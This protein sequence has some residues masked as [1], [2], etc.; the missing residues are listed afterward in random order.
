[1]GCYVPCAQEECEGDAEVEHDGDGEDALLE[2]CG[3]RVDVRY[4]DSVSTECGEEVG[5][6][7]GSGREGLGNGG[8]GG[9][10]A[11]D[12]DAL[13]YFGRHG[14]VLC[15]RTVYVVVLWV[16]PRANTRGILT[17]Y[18]TIYGV[19]LAG[20][21]S[22][23]WVRSYVTD[24]R[25]NLGGGLCGGVQVRRRGSSGATWGSSKSHCLN[26]SSELTSNARDACPHSKSS[27]FEA[28]DSVS[29]SC[30]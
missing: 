18:L 2:P 21:N 4:V 10:G 1:V 6:L 5:E 12:G 19:L 26:S 30:C 8:L 9:F 7:D 23:T 11:F 22:L 25:R 14:E 28:G 29:R 16:M 24:Y 13:L 3:V 27:I 17:D 20:L 15:G